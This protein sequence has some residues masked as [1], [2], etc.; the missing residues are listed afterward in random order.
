MADLSDLSLRDRLWYH[1]YRFR[2]V[3]PLPWVEGGPPVSRSRVALV[4]T[5]GLHLPDQAPFQ[6]IGGGDF[7]YRV[8]PDQARPTELVCTHP[9]RSWDRAG[10]AADP[11]VAFPLERLK[12]MAERGEVG[13]VS[14]VHLSFQG[15]ITA[16]L[17]LVRQTAPEAAHLLLRE[18]VHVALLAPV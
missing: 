16:P 3:D 15:S 13:E 9:S 12:E 11:N 4:T 5:A 2:R 18:Q 7:S 8:I 14:P 10:V 17:R 6:K 1:T